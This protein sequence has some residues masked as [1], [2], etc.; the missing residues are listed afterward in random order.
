MPV[1]LQFLGYFWAFQ[2]RQGHR[3][4]SLQMAD[5]SAPVCTLYIWVSNKSD[6]TAAGGNRTLDSSLEGSG[7]TTMQ[8]PQDL[9]GHCIIGFEKY[10]NPNFLWQH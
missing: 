8:Q 10:T 9:D 5:P 1:V 3:L 7:I 4:E 6:K 2:H